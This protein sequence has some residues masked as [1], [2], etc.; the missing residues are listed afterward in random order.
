MGRDG[1]SLSGGGDPDDINNW[2]KRCSWLYDAYGFITE[3]E[4]SAYMLIVI[5]VLGVVWA[6]AVVGTLL[7]HRPSPT[8]GAMRLVVFGVSAAVAAGIPHA[9]ASVLLARKID[10]LILLLAVPGV[11]MAAFCLAL[12]RRSMPLLCAAGIYGLELA[13]GCLVG[14]MISPSSIERS[15]D[16]KPQYLTIPAGVILLGYL[17]CAAGRRIRHHLTREVRSAR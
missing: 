4:A 15:L 10:D 12:P 5:G 6:A 8:G 11:V 13:V 9:V 17:A 2:D 7:T 3:D 1:K 16:G 14:M